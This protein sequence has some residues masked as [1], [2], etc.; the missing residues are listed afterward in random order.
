MILAQFL[1]ALR[2]RP[3]TPLSESIL[4]NMFEI[5]PIIHEAQELFRFLLAF[6]MNFIFHRI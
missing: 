2:S 1:I 4:F 3:E 6:G 5:G